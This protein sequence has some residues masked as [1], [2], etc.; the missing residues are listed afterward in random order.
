LGKLFRKDGQGSFAVK[1]LYENLIQ[2]PNCKAFHGRS[3]L[4][5]SLPWPGSEPGFFCF[6]HSYFLSLDYWATMAEI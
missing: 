4:F 1:Q 6:F 2:M 5:K 3:T